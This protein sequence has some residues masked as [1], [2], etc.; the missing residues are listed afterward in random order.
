MEREIA[1]AIPR[2]DIVLLED[3]RLAAMEYRSGAARQLQAAPFYPRYR[4]NE[5]KSRW[6]RA[7]EALIC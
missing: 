4:V 5:P 6:N 3:V 7:F 1:S 2:E